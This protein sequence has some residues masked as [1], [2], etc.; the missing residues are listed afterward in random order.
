MQIDVMALAQ[1]FVDEL[2][3]RSIK[4]A[5]FEDSD[6][7]AISVKITTGFKIE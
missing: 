1:A 7:E 5:P 3:T 6:N 2:K 4:I